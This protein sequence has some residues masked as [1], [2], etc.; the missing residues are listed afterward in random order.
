MTGFNRISTGQRPAAS[1]QNR[2]SVVTFR[3]DAFFIPRTCLTAKISLPVTPSVIW[4]N[5]QHVP[6][7]VMNNR[8]KLVIALGAMLNCFLIDFVFH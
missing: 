6:G 7:E 3:F 4:H 5:G 1:G 2:T 8:R